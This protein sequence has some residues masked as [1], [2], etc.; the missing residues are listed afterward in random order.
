M[1]LLDALNQIPEFRQ[2]TGKRHA[3]GHVLV[4]LVLSMLSGNDTWRSHEE[5]VQRHREALL[6]HLRP[7]KDR[8]PSY[9]TF[10]R[11]MKDLGFGALHAAFLG[12]ARKH[13]PIQEGEW[14]SADGK[15]LRGTITGACEAEQD[16]TALVSLYSHKRGIVLR[17]RAYENKAESEIHVVQALLA[18]TPLKGANLTLDALH[19]TKKRAS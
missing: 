15:S 17:S 11:V 13:V 8:L 1:S 6:E 3:L 12:W 10:R 19:C 16:F 4:C 18:E 5:F 9:S 2:A 7:D 14:L